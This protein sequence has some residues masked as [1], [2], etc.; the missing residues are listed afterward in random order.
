MKFYD[1]NVK[2]I[3]TQS[4]FNYVKNTY[5]HLRKNGKSPQEIEKMLHEA[6]NEIFNETLESNLKWWNENFSDSYVK[7][8]EQ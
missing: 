4:I 3:A 8:V 1:Y 6:F 2:A 5:P 7:A